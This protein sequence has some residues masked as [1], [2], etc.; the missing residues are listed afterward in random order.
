MTY[1]KE[2]KLEILG[3]SVFSECSGLWK[4]QIKPAKYGISKT[5]EYGQKLDLARNVQV[6]EEYIYTNS[7]IKNTH[8]HS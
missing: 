8:L 1:E 6:G 5:W 2:L 7:K 4:T 3:E